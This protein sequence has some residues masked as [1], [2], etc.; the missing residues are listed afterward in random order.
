[1]AHD[2]LIL[3][4]AFWRQRQEDIFA[5]EASLVYRESYTPARVT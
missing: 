1:M 4:P 5:L 2:F 3:S